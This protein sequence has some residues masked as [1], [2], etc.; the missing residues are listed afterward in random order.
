[1]E[2]QPEVADRLAD[3]P[4]IEQLRDTMI[5]GDLE[6]RVLDRLAA[7]S[8]LRSFDAG[9]RLYAQGDQNIPLCIVISG[10]LSFFRTAPDGT[11]MLLPL[12]AI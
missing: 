9:T 12:P 11:V 3:R 5:F 4:A 10:Q 6:D 2:R 1:M 7:I 8:E